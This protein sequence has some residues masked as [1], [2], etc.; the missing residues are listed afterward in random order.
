MSTKRCLPGRLPDLHPMSGLEPLA[1]PIDQAHKGDR[2]TEDA[3][4]KPRKAV[5]PLLFR[6]VENSKT[7]KCGK[8]LFFVRRQRRSRPAGCSSQQP[9]PQP[10]SRVRARK[11]SDEPIGY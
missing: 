5:K 6:S 1:F 3:C 2:Y 10:C 11:G 4:G 7:V 9:G 8:A